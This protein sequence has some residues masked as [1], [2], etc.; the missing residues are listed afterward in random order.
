MNVMDLSQVL[1]WSLFND[2]VWLYVEA[3]RRLIREVGPTLKTEAARSSETLLS[4]HH[5]TRRNNPKEPQI[6]S[7]LF[8]FLHEVA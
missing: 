1:Y 8:F 2:A 7:P 6:N 5:T 4:N 3:S